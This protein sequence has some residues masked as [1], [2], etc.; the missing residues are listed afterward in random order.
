MIQETA[1]AA[2]GEWETFYLIIGTAAG[3]LTGLQFVV[4]TLVSE[5]MIGRPGNGAI[6]AFGT[7]TV[8]H[9]CAALL[10]SAILSAPW[11]DLAGPALMVAA[12]GV[13]GLIYT[14]IIV[15]RARRQTGYTMVAEDWIWHIILP[16]IAYGTQVA[17]GEL[18]RTR[19]VLALFLAG[20]STVLLVFI[21]IHNAWDTTTFVAD[22][23]QRQSETLQPVTTSPAV[24]SVPGMPA[25]VAVPAVDGTRA[26]SGTPSPPSPPS[27]AA[28]DANR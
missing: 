28:T 13:V 7:P 18:L 3:A 10:V 1:H 4:M 11:P 22:L 23:R 26:I 15:R 27:I 12:T 24:P 5:T 8:V 2:L 17:C 20:G 25:E 19:T 16:P 14:A 6:D 9:F 21:G